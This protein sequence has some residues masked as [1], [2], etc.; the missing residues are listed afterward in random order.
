MWY[1]IGGIII[2]L[3]IGYMIGRSVFSAKSRDES[4]SKS[5]DESVSKDSSRDEDPDSNRFTIRAANL[6]KLRAFAKKNK[7]FT[8]Q[9]VESE[10]AVSDPTATRYCDE[11]EKEGLITQ[12]GKSG[13]HVKYKS[14]L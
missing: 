12:D 11:L 3:A 1:G 6:E 2:G 13:P 14:K 9:D 5:R 10:L 7:T 8:N 4:V